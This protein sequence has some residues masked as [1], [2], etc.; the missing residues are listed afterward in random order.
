MY[1]FPYAYIQNPYVIFRCPLYAQKAALFPGCSFAVGYD[2]AER[3]LNP[4]YYPEGLEAGL[5]GLRACTVVVGGRIAL[6]PVTK[7]PAEPARFLTLGD[8]QVPSGL[9]DMFLPLSEPE[10]RDDISSSLLRQ[11]ASAKIAN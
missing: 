4:K 1:I 6:D 2:T 11:R 7:L 9:K 5:Q 10:F 8:L 3:I